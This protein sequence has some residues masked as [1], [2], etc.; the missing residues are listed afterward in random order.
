M[1]AVAVIEI[2]FDVLYLLTVILIGIVMVAKSKGQNQF[3]LFG[4]MAIVLGIGDTFHLLPRIYGLLTNSLE[5]HEMLLG[6]GKLITSVTMTI[7]YIILYRFWQL[8]YNKNNEWLNV[9]VY[10][11]SIVRVFICLFPQNEWLSSKP[12]VSWGIYR[13]IPFVILG[14]I[15]AVS[16]LKTTSKG[17]DNE[18]HFMPLAIL[19][20][21]A[22][23]IPVVL[24]SNVFPPVAMLMIP[25]T[26]SYLAIVLMGYISMNNAIKNKIIDK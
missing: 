24:F 20:S 22:F 13:N 14:I 8:R 7:F 12:P 25:K 17:K 3:Q 4:V 9:F 26:I 16:F 19:L 23:Y 2:L 15:T 21:F 10:F 11:V 6:L 18:Y 5:T 1:S